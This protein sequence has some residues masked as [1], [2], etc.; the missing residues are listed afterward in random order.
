VVDGPG[1]GGLVG[2][3]T[4]TARLA[5]MHLGDGE[6]DGARILRPD[7][8]RLMRTITAPGKPFDLGLGW[9]RKPVDATTTAVEHL[10]AGGGFFNA[11]RLYPELGVGIV[12]MAN[13]TAAYDHAPLFDAIARL[14][15]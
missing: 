10:G 4:D 14:A 7:T 1:Y 15:W 3:V 12:A 13:T 9:F 6:L 5:A 2:P 11:M 8:A